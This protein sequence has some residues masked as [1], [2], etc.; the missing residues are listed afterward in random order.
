MRS[1]WFKLTAALVLVTLMGVGLSILIPRVVTIRSFAS[2][3]NRSRAEERTGL[4]E[5]LATYYSSQGSWEAVDSLVFWFPG[6]MGHGMGPGGLPGMMPGVTRPWRFKLA[7]E[8]GVVIAPSR[9]VD[10]GQELSPDELAAS[11]PLAVEG[12]TIGFLLPSPLMDSFSDLESAFL[13]QVSRTIVPVGTAACAVAILLGLLLTWQLTGPLRKLTTATQGIAGGDLSQRVDIRSGDEI[14]ELGKAFNDMAE[15]LARAEKLRR[16]M[17]ADI[18][19][20]LRT[21]LSVMRGNLEAIVDG[22]FEPTEENIAA[23]HKETVLL[24]RLVDDLQELA[25]AEAGQLKIEREP[26]NLA[27]LIERTVAS[28]ARRAGKDNITIVRDLPADLPLVNADPQRIGQVLFNL[29]DN[30]LRHS[31]AGAAITVKATELE[32]AVQVDVTDQG[33]GLDEQEL[34]LVFERFYRGDKARSR[35]TGGAGLGLT[36]VKQLVEA[37]EGEVW[38]QSDAG[39]GATFSFALPL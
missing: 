14:G 13:G 23:I 2:F 15:S 31:P 33:A 16:N 1:L 8:N 21:P 22:V 7:D 38:A 32:E 11:I 28:V 19:H 24:S 6:R 39:R 37:H 5:A 20:E 36:I 35:V 3:V 30:A 26:T 17:V 27:S 29:L 4:A 9:S 25:L 10:I 18:A 34:P 12:Q